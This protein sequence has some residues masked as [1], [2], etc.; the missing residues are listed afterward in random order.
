M[1]KKTVLSQLTSEFSFESFNHL[2]NASRYVLSVTRCF[3]MC[4]NFLM[5]IFCPTI[6]DMFHDM[7]VY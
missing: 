4:L 2:R 5:M 1:L 7:F 6:H 3:T